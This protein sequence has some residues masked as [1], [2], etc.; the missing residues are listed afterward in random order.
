MWIR[1]GPSSPRAWTSAKTDTNLGL[2]GPQI[3]LVWALLLLLRA[4]DCE[5]PK[6]RRLRHVHSASSCV[7]FEDFFRRGC[8]R[9]RASYCLLSS[10][11]VVDCTGP[12]VRR[13][14]HNC[15]KQPVRGL[16]SDLETTT[17]LFTRDCVPQS[18]MEGLP[19]V[20][21]FV[22]AA[23]ICATKIMQYLD[24]QRICAGLSEYLL[25]A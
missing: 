19:F 16:L 1:A 15:V 24:T 21:L 5:R 6:V 9:G 8:F 4:S 2:S 12:L 22:T 13:T 20:M 23:V 14:L 10:R 11:K 18:V 17:G 7:L 3:R 25:C